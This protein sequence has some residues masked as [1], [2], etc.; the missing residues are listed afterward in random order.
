[1]PDRVTCTAWCN[2]SAILAGAAQDEVHVFVPSGS[3]ASGRANS[4]TWVSSA[5]IQLPRDA[6]IA[7]ISWAPTGA[8]L[9]AAGSV[10]SVCALPDQAV[11]AAA[12]GGTATSLRAGW[13]VRLCPGNDDTAPGTPDNV[14]GD[15]EEAECVQTCTSTAPPPGTDMG[16]HRAVEL[17]A[18]GSTAFVTAA[19]ADCA[20]KLWSMDAEAVRPMVAGASTGS[21]P[22]SAVAHVGQNAPE[23]LVHT[24]P[25]LCMGWRPCTCSPCAR[26]RA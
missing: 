17:C 19:A 21:I 14:A 18:C 15:A 25:V 11:S 23:L 22:C 20:P 7:A 9:V 3:S 1:M 5:V 16:A 26:A 8:R 10:I 4:V 12:A 2:G 6:G 24:A 13:S